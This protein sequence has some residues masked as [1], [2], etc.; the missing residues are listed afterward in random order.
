[1]ETTIITW[2]LIILIGVSVLNSVFSYIGMKHH[3]EAHQDA[4]NALQGYY[5]LMDAPPMDPYDYDLSLRMRMA[6]KVVKDLTE[7]AQGLYD[8]ICQTARKQE[9]DALNAAF[10]AAR[11][12]L[13]S[14]L[15]LLEETSYYLKETRPF[16]EVDAKTA[17][18]VLLHAVVFAENLPGVQPQGSIRKTARVNAYAKKLEE[19]AVDIMETHTVLSL[20]TV[21]DIKQHLVQVGL[22]TEGQPK[23][24]ERL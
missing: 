7:E 15:L 16:M 11:K 5:D 12:M 4:S 10:V 14:Y 8:D 20:P 24:E 1:M 13:P 17:M 22:L 23:P 19:I 3:K 9:T 18:T 6:E 2:L 21:Y